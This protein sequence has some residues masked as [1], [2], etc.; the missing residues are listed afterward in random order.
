M[1]LYD[2]R[3]LRAEDPNDSVLLAERIPA[4]QVAVARE[5]SG[6]LV[7]HAG[8]H[9]IV[10]EDW[11]LWEWEKENPSYARKM[12]KILSDKEC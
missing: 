11:W 10:T 1:A 7:F 5:L 3:F 8:T 2:I 6:D 4:R 12:Q 9:K